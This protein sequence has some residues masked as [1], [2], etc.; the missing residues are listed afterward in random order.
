MGIIS[1]D[2]LLD[3]LHL[4]LSS[5]T[6][7]TVRR[8]RELIS[9]GIDPMQLTSQLAKLIMDILSGGCQLEPSRFSELLEYM[10][11]FA[12]V[13]FIFVFIFYLQQHVNFVNFLI[14]VWI[15]L[16]Q[17]TNLQF[18]L[19]IHQSCMLLYISMLNYLSA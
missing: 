4:A 11:A 13:I 1:N 6:S 10:L 19:I 3:L 15:L 9:S 8:A 5:D 14:I 2:E 17:S 12:I 16:E 18:S 7:G